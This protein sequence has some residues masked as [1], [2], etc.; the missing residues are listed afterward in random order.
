VK[1]SKSLPLPKIAVIIPVYNHWNYATDCVD[2]LLAT[3]PGVHVILVDDC[4]P[5]VPPAAWLKERFHQSNGHNVYVRHP[6]NEQLT[7]AWNTGF[8]HAFRIN[9]DFIV[10]GNSDILFSPDW[11][12]ALQQASRIGYH[13]VGPMT[14]T[15]GNTKLQEITRLIPT[16]ATDHTEAGIARV[17]TALRGWRNHVEPTP[18]N[19]FFMWAK[20][21]DWKSG[22]YKENFVFRPSNSHFN[23]GKKNPTPLMTGNE[24]ELQS[25]WG[26][27]LKRKFGVACGSFI[28]HYRSVTRG[29]HYA[30]GRWSRK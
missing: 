29:I 30:K 14:N 22:A 7:A 6:K 23:S 17:S 15:P 18:I 20:T 27:K 13:L 8:R 21:A 28:F 5:E 26:N 2:S 11:W 4:S 24:D 12:I 10:A 9:P 19:G 16:Y 3:T 1:T 25:R